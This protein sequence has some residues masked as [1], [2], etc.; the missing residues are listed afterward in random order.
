MQSKN[1]AQ[2]LALK[3]DPNK[4]ALLWQ[5]QLDKEKVCQ[6]K[7]KRKKIP[8][9]QNLAVQVE[10]KAIH[11]DHKTEILKDKIR[12]RKEMTAKRNGNQ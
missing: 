12:Q 6:I 5:V 2:I 3:Y 11:H 4:P 9:D 7:V 10:D 8:R 1:N